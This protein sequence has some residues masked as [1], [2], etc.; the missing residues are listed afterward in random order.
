MGGPHGETVFPTQIKPHFQ[1]YET[2]QKSKPHDVCVSEGV[3]FVC[4]FVSAWLFCCL[5]PSCPHLLFCKGS[6]L[7]PAGAMDQAALQQVALVRTSGSLL[8]SLERPWAAK[9]AHM[10]REF[11]FR[12]S[13]FSA[14]PLVGRVV[15]ILDFG[16]TLLFCYAAMHCRYFAET[17]TLWEHVNSSAD[18]FQFGA[19]ETV[20]FWWCVYYAASLSISTTARCWL[21]LIVSG[22]VPFLTRHGSLIHS[23]MNKFVVPGYGWSLTQPCVT[24][25]SLPLGRSP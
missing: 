16:L 12:I 23:E 8:D 10:D 22:R 13:G 18:I 14:G 17:K 21:C 3:V 5:D 11:L 15:F 9:S 6:R 25:Q 4:V 1:A 7:Q 24:A 2:T 20:L 19:V